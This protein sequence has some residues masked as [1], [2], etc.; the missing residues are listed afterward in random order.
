MIAQCFSGL[1]RRY[2]PRN[3][4]K[5]KAR[6]DGVEKVRKV[7]R[8]ALTRNDG[9]A[10]SRSDDKTGLFSL[11]ISVRVVGRALTIRVKRYII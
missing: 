10:V 5:G 6:N 2:A 1:L 9:R 11:F 8:Y 4:G 3:D 7:A